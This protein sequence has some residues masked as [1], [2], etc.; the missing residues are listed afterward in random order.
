MPKPKSPSTAKKPAADPE[1]AELPPPIVP[2]TAEQDLLGRALR[3]LVNI[4]AAPFAARARQEGY[5]PQEHREGWRLFKVASGEERPWEHLAIETSTA[6]A[7]EGAERL[8]LLQEIDHFENTWF[9]RARAIIRRVVHRDRRDGF[10]GTFFNNLAQQPLGPGVIG[11]VGTF[12]SRVDA[13][14]Q[15]G[16]EDGKKVRKTLAERGLTD[17]KIKQIRS[18]LGKLQGS[19]GAPV[20]AKVPIADIVKAQQEQR[21]ALEGLRDW[22]NDWGTTFRQIFHV[23]AQLQLGL[24]T[25]KRDAGGDDLVSEGE[26]DAEDETAAEEP[27][28][29]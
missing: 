3:F 12:L 1:P 2:T 25:V 11:S 9:P 7:A 20:P 27:E 23:K 16:G 13:L 21:G 14:A 26:G 29:G 18:L 6:G 17:E 22:F 4:Q 5:T 28:N 15:S 8:R 10:E 19:G 24:T